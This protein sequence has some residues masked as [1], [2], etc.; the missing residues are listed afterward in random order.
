M[1]KKSVI[2]SSVLALVS[3]Y[4][5]MGHARSIGS[6]S[7]KAQ[8]AAEVIN[9]AVNSNDHAIPQSLLEK[10]LCVVTIPD[11]MRM[12]LGIG[13]RVGRGLVSCRGAEGW[14]RRVEQTFLY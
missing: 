10:S 5:L 8:R 2:L 3:T 9:E 7:N 1:K 4:S 13:A 6:L 14:S 12:G 11:V